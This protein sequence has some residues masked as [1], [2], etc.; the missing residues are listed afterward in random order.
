MSD[1]VVDPEDAEGEEKAEDYGSLSVE[2]DPEGTVDPA[3][4]A[5]TA[6]TGDAGVGYEPEFT[7]ADD[8]V[9]DV[10]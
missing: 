7:E 6:S 4:L 9:D 2:D 3:E 5:G 1:H 8:D 10:E